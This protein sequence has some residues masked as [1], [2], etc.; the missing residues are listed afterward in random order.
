MRKNL[1]NN[2]L[3]LDLLSQGYSRI[4]GIDEVGRGAFAGPVFVVG[5]LYSLKTPYL[6]EVQDSKK[7]SDRKRITLFSILNTLDHITKVG[8]VETINK[9]GIGKTIETLISEI[10]LEQTSYDTFFLI[11]GYFKPDFGKNTRQIKGG[12][13]LHYSISSASVIAKVQRDTYMR[14]I[15]S[16]YPQ[17]HL[18][19]N[20]GYG[21][22][23]HID[24]LY[25]YGI[26]N[27]HRRNFRPIMRLLPTCEQTNT[28]KQ[29]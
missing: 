29:S 18:D 5:F 9:L 11:D 28:R 14:K 16:Q 17:Y 25:T 19:K 23:T 20:V 2:T 8:S 12:D 27:Q 24:A 13:N 10:V 26:T 6:D 22:A 7:L 21:T 15:S 1:P 4:I 3:E